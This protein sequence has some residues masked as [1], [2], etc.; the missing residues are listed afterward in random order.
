MVMTMERVQLS[1]EQAINLVR[2]CITAAL[3]KDHELCQGL[4]QAFL[5]GYSEAGLTDGEIKAVRGAKEAL[6]DGMKLIYGIC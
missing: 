6:D 4:R 5:E 3:K 2:A 1:P